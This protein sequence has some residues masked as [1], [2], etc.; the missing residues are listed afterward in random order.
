MVFK[1]LCVF[2]LWTKV[3]SALEGLTRLTVLMVLFFWSFPGSRLKSSDR[4]MRR[5]RKLSSEPT[6]GSTIGVR[7]PQQRQQQLL[8]R[9]HDE[10]FD[11][12]EDEQK[13]SSLESLRIRSP[14][15]PQPPS[16]ETRPF[17]GP[18]IGSGKFR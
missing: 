11:A 6:E 18:V 2:V 4:R 8:Y 5:F 12:E 17:S 16:E 14:S 9:T 3:S 1:N 15:L 13:S 10:S 7:S